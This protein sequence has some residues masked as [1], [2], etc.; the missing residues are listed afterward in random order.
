MKS[1]IVG[2]PL[3]RMAIDITDPFHESRFV[4]VVMD[5]FTKWVELIAMPNHTTETVSQ[6]FTRVSIP[7]FLHSNQ[8][9]NFLSS[10]FVETCLRFG[11]KRTQTNPW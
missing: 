4:A 1:F 2:E 7:K 10:L 11:I 9:T 8:E 3:E 6:V 5:Y